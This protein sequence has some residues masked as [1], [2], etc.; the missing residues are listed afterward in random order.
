[1]LKEWKKL[2]RSASILIMAIAITQGARKMK[3]HSPQPTKVVYNFI[4]FHS[5]LLNGSFLAMIGPFLPMN[6]KW[7]FGVYN[8]KN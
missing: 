2:K 1:L 8:K 5:H 3:H 7:N 4:I 6:G